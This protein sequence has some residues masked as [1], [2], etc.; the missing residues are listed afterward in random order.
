MGYGEWT[1][2]G[3]EEGRR[4]CMCEGVCVV[5]QGGRERGRGLG[6]W[7]LCVFEEGK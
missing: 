4:G 6:D 2:G 5:V 7:V 1:V 3:G